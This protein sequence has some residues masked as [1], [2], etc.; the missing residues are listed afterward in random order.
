MP[1]MSFKTD[2]AFRD[3]LQALAR[4]KGVNTSAY[5]KLLLTQEITQELATVTQ[6]GLTIAEEMR[7]LHSDAHDKTVGPFTSAK[8]LFAALK[9]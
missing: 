1:T 4:K 8:K 2:V 6:N 7:I 5:I 3:T 9:K